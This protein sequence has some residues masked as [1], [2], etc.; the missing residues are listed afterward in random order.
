MTV[1]DSVV[2]V[3]GGA[4]GI[5]RA[6]ARRFVREGARAVAVI[7]RDHAAG[8]VAHQIGARA[9]IA[10]VG[11]EHQLARVIE[12]IHAEY[13]A[14]DLFCSNAGIGAGDGGL[15]TSDD[16]WQRIWHVNVMAHIYAARAV[17]PLMLTAGHGYLLQTAS[18]A[19]LLTQLGSAPY[20]ATR[21][22]A[23]HSAPTRTIL[24]RGCGVV[25]LTYD[26]NLTGLEGTRST[27]AKRSHM[28]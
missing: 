14:I 20:A 9:Y 27:C 19:G 1:R 2:V 3:T 13:G 28:N 10:D 18:A 4:S 26:S 16:D 15:D 12:E 6:L 24:R 7:D 21:L 22:V 17:L 8:D 25:R 5:G 11:V 23:P